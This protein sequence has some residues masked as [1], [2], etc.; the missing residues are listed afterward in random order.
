MKLI[1]LTSIFFLLFLLIGCQNQNKREERSITPEFTQQVLQAN[2]ASLMRFENHLVFDGFDWG[3]IVIRGG[4]DT[5][6]VES[7]E[8]AFTFGIPLDVIIGWPSLYS[9][10]VMEAINT[11]EL[12]LKADLDERGLSIE[13]FGLSLPLT[14]DDLIYNW[15]EISLLHFEGMSQDFRDRIF[16]QAEVIYGQET[17]KNRTIRRWLF[18]GV[19]DNL[20]AFLEGR[21]MSEEDLIL[22]NDRRERFNRITVTI[23]ELP[24]FPITETDVRNNPWIIED[25]ISVLLT[26]DEIRSLE[27]RNLIIEQLEY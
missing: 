16:S 17:C 4:I 9:L 12:T 11:A 10:G 18:P 21:E 25:I 20:N 8:A 15:Y 6:F 23:D 14:I 19:L 5:I 27:P 22:L 13:S 7:E 1:F 24:I 2:Y 3:G 26:N